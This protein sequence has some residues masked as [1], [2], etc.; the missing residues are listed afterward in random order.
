MYAKD[1]HRQVQNR[2]FNTPA[3]AAGFSQQLLLATPRDG[4]CTQALPDANCLSSRKKSH[5][6]TGIDQQ[7]NMHR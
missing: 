2:H 6:V 7:F 1:T 3:N 4:K 5:H